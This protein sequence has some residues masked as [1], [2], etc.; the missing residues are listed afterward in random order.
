MSPTESIEQMNCCASPAGLTRW[1]RNPFRH[2]KK[3]SPSDH[4]FGCTFSSV[5]RQVRTLR[6]CCGF[7]AHCYS[8]W[9]V[10]ETTEGTSLNLTS[11]DGFPEII[12]RGSLSWQDVS[13]IGP[14]VVGPVP[15]RQAELCYRLARRPVQRALSTSTP[16]PASMAASNSDTVPSN[17]AHRQLEIIKR[18]SS[19][20]TAVCF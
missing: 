13:A 12:S 2:I 5:W 11:M 7:E 4:I 10:C 1:P 17:A 14:D 19:R 20:T 16:T 9:G 3:S 8:L 15:A 18:P 6:N